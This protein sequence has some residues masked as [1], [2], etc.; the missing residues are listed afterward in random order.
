MACKPEAWMRTARGVRV[1]PCVGQRDAGLRF[2]RDA[3]H[4]FGPG[5]QS[6]V[7]P[8]AA[9][10]GLAQG[11]SPQLWHQLCAVRSCQALQ[12]LPAEGTSRQ[13]S[14]C[15][16]SLGS[17]NTPAACALEVNPK[18]AKSFSIGKERPHRSG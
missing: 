12:Q 7:W 11:C 4:R 1:W 17:V 18:Q 10:P 16:S 3:G 13:G 2:G 9:L 15:L 6:Q 8:R 5:L 14:A